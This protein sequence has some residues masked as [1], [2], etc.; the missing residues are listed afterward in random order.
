[1]SFLKEKVIGLDLFAAPPILRAKGA[2]ETKNLCGGVLS[3]LLLLVFLYVFFLSFQSIL[4]YSRMEI[5]SHLDILDQG[6]GEIH[7]I[8]LAVGLGNAN[9]FGFLF[10]IARITLKKTKRVTIADGSYDDE[11]VEI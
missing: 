9:Y 7:N 10:S 1:M 2:P 8:F 4:N 3:F 11:V 6:E 5:F